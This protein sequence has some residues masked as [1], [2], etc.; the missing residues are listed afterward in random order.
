MPWRRVSYPSSLRTWCFNELVS[1]LIEYI[2]DFV[3]SNPL[4]RSH[5]HFILICLAFLR[6]KVL[7]TIRG[8]ELLSIYAITISKHYCNTNELIIQCSLGVETP[9]IA[10]AM[11]LSTSHPIDWPLFSKIV[12]ADVLR[13]LLPITKVF[14]NYTNIKYTRGHGQLRLSQYK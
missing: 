1:L 3:L 4:S 12:T 7:R 13:S 11:P 6:W 9:D 14:A 8:V 10:A 2:S 5:F